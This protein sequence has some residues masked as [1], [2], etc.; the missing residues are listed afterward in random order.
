MGAPQ[1]S[2]TLLWC[3]NNSAIQIAHN[4][5]FHERTK[6]IEIDCHFVR[7]HVVR[8]TIQLQ[9]ISTIDQPA[10]IFTKAHLPGHFQELV[11]KLN[12]VTSINFGYDSRFKE[13][14]FSCH[15]NFF[16][17]SGEM[18]PKLLSPETIYACYL[19]YEITENHSHFL[20]PFKVLFSHNN[21]LN[22]CF[23]DSYGLYLVSP[24]T[25][26]ISQKDDRNTH[27]PSDIPKFK[28]LWQP[29][30]DG[31]MEVQVCEFKNDT[32]FDTSLLQF[33]LLI[34]VDS[35]H[36]TFDGLVVQ[37]FE[38]KPPFFLDEFQHLKIQQEEIRSATDDFA[39]NKVIG[40]GGFGKVYKGE[41]SRSR[42]RSMVAFKRLDGRLGKG[43][44]EFRKEIMML[45]RY[46]HENLVSLLGYCDEGGGKILVYE[47]GS[48]GSLDRYLSVT[49][50]A[51]TQR[52]KICLGVSS[53]LSYRLAPNESQQRVIHRDIKSANILLD[54]NW[55]AKV[56]DFGLSKIGPTNQPHTAVV[57]NVEG[58]IGYLDPLYLDV[59]ALTKESDVYSFGVVLFETLYGRLCFEYSNRKHFQTLHIYACKNLV[60]NVH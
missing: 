20:H 9:P 57:F 12:L 56:S 51:W 18:E 25:R 23:N 52:L 60:K 10:D 44:L 28:G 34:G 55:K 32:T 4:D 27:N 40:V 41:I 21:L 19:V 8:N 11:S 42:G 50:I 48:R 3:D 37:G 49:A 35:D 53:G 13:V 26:V 15:C 2:P 22:L 47:Y 30:K 58:T 54:E 16:N 46:T 17:I 6:H 29:R 1:L 45:F 7:Q 14:A 36:Q 38:F 33:E 24:Q 39:D 43:N 31:W 59:G 5:V